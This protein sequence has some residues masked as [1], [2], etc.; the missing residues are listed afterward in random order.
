[1][2]IKLFEDF[3]SDVDNMILEIDKECEMD[4]YQQPQVRVTNPNVFGEFMSYLWEIAEYSRID[5]LGGT[6]AKS[7]IRRYDISDKVNFEDIIHMA[8]TGIGSGIKIVKYPLSRWMEWDEWPG[9]YIEG[10]I[11]MKSDDPRF[12]EYF[13]WTYIRPEKLRDILEKFI[14]TLELLN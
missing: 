3:N 13:I 12:G 10:F 4:K 11:R 5:A 1:M 9:G 2:R 14:D 8:P 7:G 6:E